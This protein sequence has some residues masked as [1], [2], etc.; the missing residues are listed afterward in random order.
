MIALFATPEGA[1]RFVS[2][3]PAQAAA[4][5]YRDAQGI[6]VSSLGL[7]SYLGEMDEATDRGYRES[8]VEA[9]SGGVNFLD[10]SLNYRHQRSELAIGAALGDLLRR[11][12]LK[13]DEFMVSTKAG[14][15]TPNAMPHTALRP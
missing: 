13:R 14:F 11:G 1:A 3:F 2:R 8:V 6:K 9:M 15:L 12:E 4:G 10:T 7:G 5:F